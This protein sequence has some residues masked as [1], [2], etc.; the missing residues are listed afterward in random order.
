MLRKGAALLMFLALAAG[1]W[2]QGL[3]LPPGVTKDDWEEINFEFNSSVLVDGFPSLLRLAELLQQN[4]G[5]KVQVDGHTNVIGGTQ[6]NDRLGLARANAVRD[7]LIKYGAQ[8]G[9]ISATSEG[10]ISPRY[11]GQRDAY[12]K[13]DEARYMNRRVSLTVTDAQGRTVGAAGGSAAEAIRALAPAGGGVTDCCSEVLKKLDKLDNIAKMLKDLGDQNADLKKQLADLKAAQDALRQNQQVL[14]SRAN[15]PPAP[16]QPAPP[17][18]GEVGRE[19]AKEIEAKKEPK[20]QM[21]GMNVGID[22]TGNTTFS[23]KGRYFSPFGEHFALQAQAEYLY[24]KTDREGQLDLGMVDRLGHFQ[25]GLFASFKHASLSQFQNGGTLGQG[26]L[27]LDY[28]FKRGKVGVFGTKGF[29]DSA[30]V[31]V[32]NATDPVS[33]ALLNHLFNYSYLQIV[34]QA[35]VSG[36]VALFGN[37]YLEGNAGYLHS[38][39]NGNRF[40]GTARFVFPLNS[41]VAL[42]LEGGINETLLEPHNSGRVVAGV[43]LGNMLRPKELLAADH[44]VPADVPRVRYEIVTKKVRNGDDPPVADAGPNQI[45]VP[46]GLITLNGSGSYSPDGNPITYSWVESVGPAVTLSAPTA[47]VTTFTA[48]AGQYY[49]FRLTV[50]DNFG[51]QGFAYVNI[52]TRATPGPAIGFFTATPAAINSGQSSTLSYSVTNATSVTISGVSG[53]LNPTTGSVPVSPTVTTTYTLTATNAIG[54]TTANVTVVVNAAVATLTSCY[55]TPTNII[56][57][58]TATLNW[59]SSGATAVSIAPGIG[60]VALNGNYAVTPTATTTYTITATGPG[61]ATAT[62]SIAVTVTPGQMPRI[63]RFSA[64]PPTIHSGQSSTLSWVVDNANTVSINNGVGSVTMDGSQSVSPTTTTAYTLTATNSFGSVTAMATVTVIVI[65]PPTITSF[66]ASPSPSPG[67]GTKVTLTCVT[68]NAVNVNIA[69]AMFLGATDSFVVFPN[70]T[71]T[72]TCIATNQPGQVAQASV[73]VVVPPSPAPSGPPPVVVFAGG[74]TITTTVRTLTLDA[75]QS[76]SPAGYTPLSF[77]WSVAAGNGAGIVGA[78]TATP[79]VTLGVPDGEYD[80][81]VVVTDSKGNS[82]SGVMHVML[83]STATTN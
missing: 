38:Q 8:P 81:Q 72:Y 24:F 36:T 40:G 21:L 7:F 71:T 48:V 78:T 18:A 15:Q 6:Y 70:V 82:A 41:H 35:G 32:A 77:F 52:S 46:A 64:T 4:P 28:I 75:S 58:E 13:T 22:D 2:G 34:D 49:S 1:A 29:M 69:G 59:M 12:S 51:G 61:G 31:N 53:T 68:Q 11:P 33:G 80:F 20:F 62:C 43:E 76:S 67:P 66:T 9:Q 55:A 79:S 65:P 30:L 17:T 57:G 83:V 50:K 44:A 5:Y 39:V 14:E 25:A 56:S 27:T 10:K 37:T 42:T 63:I 74:N 60:A 54:S 26:A 16:P 23:G 19:V 73:T 47:A 45:N 3:N